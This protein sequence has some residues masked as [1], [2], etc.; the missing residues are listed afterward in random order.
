GKIV[1]NLHYGPYTK[2]WWISR[3]TNDINDA[4]LCPIRLSIKT[5]TTINQC[6][7][8]ATAFLTK[9]R[10]DSSSFMGFDSSEIRK[11]LLS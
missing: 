10:L 8:I 2:D 3:P 6:D 1:S 11:M 4:F 7:F 9:T 5:I